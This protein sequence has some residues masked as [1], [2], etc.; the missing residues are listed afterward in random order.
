LIDEAQ[1]LPPSSLISLLRLYERQVGGGPLLSLVL[2]ANE[3]ID[4]LLS[5]PQLQIMSPHAIQVIDLSPLTREEADSYMRY[6]LKQEGLEESLALDAS[7]MNRIY[8]ETKGAPGPLGNAILKEVGDQGDTS[9]GS[10]LK[11]G[12]P[13]LWAGVPLGVL[14]LLVLLFQGPINRMFSPQ[15]EPSG[16]PVI[17]ETPGTETDESMLAGDS[18]SE[19]PPIL[20]PQPGRPEQA[21][22]PEPAG[23]AVSEGSPPAP[24]EPFAVEEAVE[25]LVPQPEEAQ[26]ESSE[27]LPTQAPH[28][29]P[30]LASVGEPVSEPLAQPDTGIP[31]SE[32]ETAQKA[33]E[34]PDTPPASAP[35]TGTAPAEPATAAPE[36]REATILLEGSGKRSGLLR[37]AGWLSEQP[38]GS[39]TLQLLAVGNIESVKA[40]V[41]KYGLQ[42][43]AF[44]IEG[45]RQGRPWYPLLWG[46]YPDKESALGAIT[47]LP[48]ELQ[49]SGAWA[50]SL[51]SLKP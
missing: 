24:T 42:E 4:M 9:A 13:L 23:L 47:R 21:P 36:Q 10:G 26:A 20:L 43:Q 34:V 6:L 1:Q 28:L 31:P 44:S 17:A 46:V 33:P 8:R 29:P 25:S 22:M 12:G 2:F 3:Q 32:P 35:K 40:A 5:T 45:K 16:G 50:R 48:P 51:V 30:A 49:K 11:I 14:L 27:P 7:H 37:T 19:P 41:A 18:P 39:Y 15:V 38:A